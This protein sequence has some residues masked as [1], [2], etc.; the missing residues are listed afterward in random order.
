MLEKKFVKSFIVLR[1][2]SSNY[3]FFAGKF[4]KLLYFFLQEKFVNFWILDVDQTLEIKE[5][6]KI[7]DRDG[8]GFIDA[9]ELKQVVTRLGQVLTSDEAD[10]FMLEADLDGDGKLDYNE[11]VRM[12]L[13]EAWSQVHFY[14]PQEKKAFELHV[15]REC[16]LHIS[17][18]I[19]LQV[20]V[21]EKK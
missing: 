4:V 18:T 12:M 16:P 7:F 14:Y 2:N 11:F 6:F 9:K 10:E 13:Q 19:W 5:A 3:W 8:N 20:K 15:P 1:K 21:N 17:L